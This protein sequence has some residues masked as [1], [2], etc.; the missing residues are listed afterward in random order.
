MGRKLDLSSL[1]A[2]E[3]Q[4]VLQVVQRDMHLRKAEEDR[5]RELRREQEENRRR[6]ALLSRQRGFTRRCC[7]CCCSPFSF[8]LAPRLTC[9]DCGHH[10]CRSCCRY[11]HQGWI[12]SACQRT[13]LLKAGSLEWFYSS[14]RRRFK[15]FGSAKVLKTLYRKLL[16]PQDSQGEFTGRSTCAESTGGDSS[17]YESDSTFYRHSEEH[18][19]AETTGVARR[20]AEEAVDEAIAK[21]QNQT[22]GEQNLKEAQYLQDNRGELIEELTTAIV[23]KIIRK[24][25][26]TSRMQPGCPAGGSSEASSPSPPGDR[27]HSSLEFRSNLNTSLRRSQSAI[28]LH[29]EDGPTQE[30]DVDQG[31]MFLPGCTRGLKKE[32]TTGPVLPIWKSVDRLDNSSASMLQSPDG[33]WIAMQSTQLSR[34]SL[35]TKRKSLVF[36]AL[37]QESGA[38]SAYD[39]LGSDTEPDADGAWGAALLQFRHK[40]SSNNASNDPRATIPQTPTDSAAE[41]FQTD[42]GQDVAAFKPHKGQFPVLKRKV[43]REHRR[44][45]ILDMN[46]YPDGTESS[47]DGLENSRAKRTRRKRRS[48]RGPAEEEGF[49]SMPSSEEDYRKMLLEV[50]TKHQMESQVDSEVEKDT[51]DTSTSDTSTSD[52]STPHA[53][54]S[55]AMTP[56]PEDEDRVTEHRLLTELIDH[57]LTPAVQLSAPFCKTKDEPDREAEIVGEANASREERMGETSWDVE[58]GEGRRGSGET[59][60]WQEREAGQKKVVI[61]PPEE[62]STA[63]SGSVEEGNIAL[64]ALNVHKKV[65]RSDRECVSSGKLNREVCADFRDEITQETTEKQ[66]EKQTERT[67]GIPQERRS[68]QDKGHEKSESDVFK[69][70]GLTTSPSATACRM[71]ERTSIERQDAEAETSGGGQTGG[72]QTGRGQELESQNGSRLKK[73]GEAARE[74]R[75]DVE[76]MLVA[77]RRGNRESTANST[78]AAESE[79]SE[80]A[81]E[82]WKKGEKDGCNELDLTR[83]EEDEAEYESMIDSVVQALDNMEKEIE[84]DMCD[85]TSDATAEQRAEEQKKVKEM[86]RF[87]E[88]EEDTGIKQDRV[89]EAKPLRVMEKDGQ[90]D[91][92]QTTEGK[93]CVMK[94]DEYRAHTVEEDLDSALSGQEFLSPEDIYKKYSAASLR[95]ITTEVLKVLNATEDLIRGTMRDGVSQSESQDPP[96]LSPAQSKRLDEQLSHLEE[97]VYVAASAAFGLEAE[98]EE[99]AECARGVCGNTTEGELAHLEEQVAS[100]AA[101]VTDIAARIAALKNAGLNVAPQTRVTKPQTIDSCRL[102][103]R[104]LPAPP[105]QDLRVCSSVPSH[106]E[107]GL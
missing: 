65:K 13:R 88:T 84:A 85:T 64:P 2:E 71:S 98:L 35:L 21:S 86:T 95:S 5:L 93:S 62:E 103:R 69:P 56:E 78:S 101:Q 29:T 83:R 40:I 45:S 57:Q 1:T 41:N 53:G 31:H 94:A 58:V 30:G 38:V 15:R 104:R 74:G 49:M 52:T 39:A 60:R 24:R 32:G 18:S 82:G 76:H 73:K 44:P 54:S 102:H 75:E 16:A 92:V 34:P 79:E 59:E 87:K 91:W 11:T 25:S 43:V 27:A 14:M 99:L 48:K 97:N 107:Q 10:V 8:L 51:S 19:L 61:P 66:S 72:G 42:S 50:L 36:S 7:M 37:E 96:S 33:N 46:F 67:A 17:V 80:T 47:E 6:C 68:G 20:V 23:E 4:H 3:A 9:L 26:D 77:E 63:F 105:V 90:H 22:H 89:N 70:E 55:G 81:P 100:A 12:C 106:R 28:A